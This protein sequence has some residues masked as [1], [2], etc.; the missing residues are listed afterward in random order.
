[1]SQKLNQTVAAPI[2]KLG[3]YAVATMGSLRHGNPYA[4]ISYKATRVGWVSFK[5]RKANP[6]TPEHEHF[7][8]AKLLVDEWFASDTNY[9]TAANTWNSMNLGVT[10]SLLA[11]K[12]EGE[13]IK[14]GRTKKN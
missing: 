7:S 13:E 14:N 9:N 8:K 11:I 10:V 2:I 12:K 5:T 4:I 3:I 1:M 6:Y